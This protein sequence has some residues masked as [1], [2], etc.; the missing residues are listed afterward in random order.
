MRN[1]WA[2]LLSLLVLAS[3]GLALSSPINE[4]QP[5]KPLDIETVRFVDLGESKTVTET[6]TDDLPSGVF[7][8]PKPDKA[9]SIRG[10]YAEAHK[11]NKL[12][13]LVAGR[14][15]VPRKS[16]RLVGRLPGD[17][18][19]PNRSF[20]T[21]L[22]KPKEFFLSERTIF[23]LGACKF[24][25]P[26]MDSE[27]AGQALYFTADIPVLATGNYTVFVRVSPEGKVFEKWK[28][29]KTIQLPD[30]S[31]L[32]CEFEIAGKE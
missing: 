20:L 24:T 3:T 26:Y 30:F 13:G 18:T 4:P 28:K 31:L 11:Q 17:G 1:S 2:L 27:P 32:K 5:V 12:E 16:L 15:R 25:G 9:L 19:G 10:Q 21:E 23:L 29:S 6:A 22:G 7:V 14:L 8:I